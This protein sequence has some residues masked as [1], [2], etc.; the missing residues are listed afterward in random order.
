MQTG[1]LPPFKLDREL[2]AQERTAWVRP[3]RPEGVPPNERSCLIRFNSTYSEFVDRKFRKRGGPVTLAVAFW[4]LVLALGSVFFVH[5]TI[6]A[7]KDRWDWYTWSISFATV[8][9]CIGAPALFWKWYLSVD[10]FTYTHYPVRFNRKTRK[11]YFFRHN[12]P[13][14]VTVVPWDDKDTY[15]HIGRGDYQKFLRDLR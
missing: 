8:A 1:W 14:G 5:N 10:F 13:G 12:G 2:N 3:N 11:V 9:L 15:F 6:Y 7:D 4:S